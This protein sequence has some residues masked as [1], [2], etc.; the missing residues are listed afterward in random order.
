MLD[1]LD[2]DWRDR[3]DQEANGGASRGDGD[4]DG[5]GRQDLQDRPLHSDP[6]LKTVDQ[7]TL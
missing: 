7:S 1:W 2:R 4:D 6:R 3:P 5:V